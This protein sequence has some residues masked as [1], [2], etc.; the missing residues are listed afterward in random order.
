M[1]ALT[2][3]PSQLTPPRVPIIDDRTGAMSRE[4][5]RFFLSLFTAVNTTTEAADTFPNGTTDAATLAA[6]LNDLSQ[7][8][9]IEPRDELGTLAPVNQDN[10]PWLTF[11]NVPSL[12]PTAV[13]SVFWNGG[14]TLN[15]QQTANVTAR[16]NEDNFFYIKAS[17][18]I[19]KG[20]L[21]MFT[22]A[23][24]ASGVLTG[25]PATGLGINDGHYLMGV[26][27]EDIALNGFGLIQWSG[28]LRGFNT[29]GS[30]Y[31]ETWADGDVLYYNPAYAGGMTKTVP[32]APNVKAVI[33]AVINAAASGS[34][35][36]TIRISFGSVLGGTDSN[37]NIGTL[38]NG[39]MLVYNS[40]NSRW[41]N[42]AVAAAQ[43]SLGLA[44]GTYTP[45]LTNTTNITSSSAGVCQYMRVGNTV[46][47]SGR[48]DVTATATGNTT[49]GISLPIASNLASNSELAGTAAY[50]SATVANN[51][52]ARISGDTTNDRATMSFNS[53]VTSS[54]S[55][56]FQFTYLIV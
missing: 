44:Y 38:A 22:G 40:A 2:P 19:T 55:W 29:T 36:I 16:T 20:Q 18:A 54:A 10:V 3:N 34:G 8:M 9:H 41:E 23:V 4:W 33:A 37:V 13:G 17:S 27:A 30:P 6:Q 39:D 35:S 43:S 49:L 45:T 26:A 14:T 7:E 5:Y 31:G 21:V 32:T 48:V 42:Y 11:S 12:V 46:T 50:T 53:T 56:F 28:T 47:V 25:A 24:G 1:V 52:F 15:I 51:S